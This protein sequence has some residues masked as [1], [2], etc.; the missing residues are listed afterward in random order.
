M[1]AVGKDLRI[2]HTGEMKNSKLMYE[3]RVI[4]VYKDTVSLPN[5]NT[6]DLDIARHPGA[7][8]VVPITDDGHFVLIHQYRYAADGYIYEV[9]AGKLDH[10]GEDPLDCAMR[11][12][13]EETGYTAKNWTKLVSIKTTPGF[14]DEIIHIFMAIGLTEGKT[15]HEHDEVIEPHL[16]TR[17][18]IEQMLD[19]GTIVDAK[20]LVG[21]YAALR[22]MDIKV[23]NEAKDSY[24]SSIL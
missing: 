24:N 9:P 13:T 17:K 11:E 4:K 6:V 2:C 1:I 5:G 19:D 21:L 23:V 22:K 10:V 8:A 15:E 14:S 12:L 16:F 7:S 3:G 18:E 20:T